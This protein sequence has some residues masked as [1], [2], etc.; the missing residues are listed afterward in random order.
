[1]HEQ[2]PFA[3]VGVTDV[4]FRTDG[5]RRDRRE[6]RMNERERVLDPNQAHKR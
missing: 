2:D 6:V 5:R 4:A 3:N 1:M